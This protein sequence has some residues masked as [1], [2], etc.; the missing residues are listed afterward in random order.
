MAFVVVA[1]NLPFI[2]TKPAVGSPEP[3]R[4]FKLTKHRT[5]GCFISM[6]TL[7]SMLFA[8]MV[9]VVEPIRGLLTPF[10]IV[11]FVPSSSTAS[12]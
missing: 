3:I 5:A 9:A 2:L 11:R 6:S 8:G 10:L 7:Y 12:L 1:I 4:F